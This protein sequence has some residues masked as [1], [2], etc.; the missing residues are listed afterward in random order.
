MTLSQQGSKDTPQV[1]EPRS[2]WVVGSARPPDWSSRQWGWKRVGLHLVAQTQ[3]ELES[4][5]YHP[6]GSTGSTVSDALSGLHR[7][8]LWAADFRRPPGKPGQP[9]PIEEAWEG[10]PA[11]GLAPAARGSGQGDP[12][13]SA[14][15]RA[16]LERKEAY[17]AFREGSRD[18]CPLACPAVRC[19]PRLP[20]LA[21]LASRRPAQAQSSHLPPARANLPRWALP[22]TP[23]FAESSGRDWLMRSP[24]GQVGRT[25]HCPPG[26]TASEYHPPPLSFPV[27]T[28]G[29]I[30]SRS[31]RNKPQP[32]LPARREA[33]DASARI[34]R[35]RVR[36]QTPL[37]SY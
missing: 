25:Q 2:C 1:Y 29:L 8:L 12:T 11:A 15:W 20:V 6:L 24:P 17:G 18:V 36:V 32:A 22:A 16:F 23:D 33:T 35:C 27:Q 3:A 5:R 26:E 31:L 13:V 19:D 4:S 21:V 37:F 28:P 7:L 34:S 30:W 14:G 9:V 10:Q